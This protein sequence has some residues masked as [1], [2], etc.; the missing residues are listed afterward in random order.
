MKD[1]L[2][3]CICIAFAYTASAAEDADELLVT[4]VR[5]EKTIIPGAS[6]KRPADYILQKIKVSSEAREEKVRKDEILETL[7]LIV[8]AAAKEKS[9]EL[10]VVLDNRIVVPFKLD[11]ATLKFARGNRT[12]TS[13]TYLSVKTKVVPGASNAVALF[14]KLK[15]F[16]T[17]IKPVGRAAIDLVGDIEVSLVN[18]SQYREEVIKLY[19]ADS[20]MVTNALGSDYRVVTKGIDRQ[21]YW[22]RD[23]MTNVIIYILYE[24]DVVPVG[25]AAYN[26]TGG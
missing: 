8:N 4:S 11:S 6:L 17:T 3:A 26:R 12:D 1:I 21:L 2:L 7:R 22:I 19:A 20:K 9:I 16:P 24:Y 25:A 23:G 10:A 15:E 18:P 14:S 13:E 5:T